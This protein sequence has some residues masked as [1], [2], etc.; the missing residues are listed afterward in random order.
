MNCVSEVRIAQVLRGGIDR[1]LV[2][3]EGAQRVLEPVVLERR[4]VQAQFLAEELEV[5]RAE[6]Q[7]IGQRRQVV[8]VGEDSCR[9][10]GTR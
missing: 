1:L 3:V 7:R 10:R 5:Q 9:R 4:A 6:T 8:V 2:R